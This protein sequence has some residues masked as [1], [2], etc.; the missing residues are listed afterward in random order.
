MTTATHLILLACIA[1]AALLT[2]GCQ[3][4]HVSHPLPAKLYTSD[5]ESQMEF[6]HSLASEKL[7]SNDEAFHGLLLYLDATDPTNNYADRVKLLKSRKLLAPSFDRPADEAV[8]R[9]TLAV[10]IVHILK[11]RG[12][13]M[14][15]AVGPE[16][17]YATREL[18]YRG[19]YP[20]SSP[21]QTFSGTEFVGVIG[22]LDDVQNG[23]PAPLTTRLKE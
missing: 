2:T 11:I 8:T 19:V 20:L 21:N 18:Q 6:W 16:P 14:M 13:I 22:K 1:A 15:H 10:A 7:A 23:V 12:G 3:S 9:G 17:R 4:A 5:S